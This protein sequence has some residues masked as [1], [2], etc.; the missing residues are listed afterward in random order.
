VTKLNI[1]IGFATY[2]AYLGVDLVEPTWQYHNDFIINEIQTAF[3]LDALTSSHPI[4]IEVG[5]PSEV[6]AIF[7]AIS[8]KKGASIIR[9]MEHFLTNSVFKKGLSNYL[10]KYSFK[11]AEQDDLWEE[12]TQEAHKSNMLNES[13]SIKE[14]MDTWTLQTGFPVVTVKRNYAS[15]E[16]L[17]EQEKFHVIPKDSKDNVLW[18]IPVTYT[19]NNEKNFNDTKPKLWLNANNYKITESIDKTHWLLVNLQ[20]TGY[21]RVNYDT[22]NWKLISE[23]LN[24][25]E[26]YKEIPIS[27][28]AQLIDDVMSLARSEYLDYSVA[29]DLTRYVIHET[30]TIPWKAFLSKMSYINGMMRKEKDYGDF[31]VC[32]EYS[33]F[34]VN[35]LVKFH[36]QDYFLQQILPIYTKIEIKTSQTEDFMSVYSMTD[37]VSYACLLGDQSCI[38]KSKNLFN[39]WMNESDPDT[40]NP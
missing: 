21:Y 22:E 16:I 30:D 39:M 31:K 3:G 37:F 38:E 20:R 26:K 15:N 33:Q 4:S 14:I 28:R 9:M 32:N 24:D 23:H 17:F 29:L 6:S 19:S 12:L 11:S 34:F 8:Y 2:V 40:T 36:L 5:H 10:K 7:D 25:P 18:W 35:F 13:S 27:N 1:S